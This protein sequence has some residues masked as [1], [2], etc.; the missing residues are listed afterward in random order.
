M[1]LFAPEKGNGSRP[2]LVYVSG[3]AGDKKVNGPDGGLFYDNVML[4][5]VKNGM[6]GVNMQRRGGFGGRGAWDEPAK[7]GRTLNRCVYE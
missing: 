3:G 4:W 1:D 7:D 5:A 6:T 2:V